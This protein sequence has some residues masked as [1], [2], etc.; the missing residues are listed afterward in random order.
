MRIKH[1]DA[2]KARGTPWYAVRKCPW[3]VS[4]CHSYFLSDSSPEQNL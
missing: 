3:H 1:D 2:G 4:F